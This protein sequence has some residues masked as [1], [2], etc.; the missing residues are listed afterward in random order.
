M[1]RAETFAIVPDQQTQEADAFWLRI[2]RSIM[3]IDLAH[4]TAISGTITGPVSDQDES[5]LLQE[6]ETAAAKVAAIGNEQLVTLDQTQLRVQPA[7]GHGDGLRFSVPA[8]DSWP[9]IAGKLRQKA[10]QPALYR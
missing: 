8:S 7:G 2:S 1:I 5:E 4:D 3:L 10:E 9:R 6:L